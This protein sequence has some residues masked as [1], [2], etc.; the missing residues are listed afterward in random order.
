MNR[1]NLPVLD[2]DDDYPSSFDQIVVPEPNCITLG[3]Q[4]NEI[5][6]RNNLC[7]FGCQSQ[8]PDMCDIYRLTHGRIGQ[9]DCVDDQRAGWAFPDCPKMLSI[10]DIADIL[11]KI[12]ISQITIEC[13]LCG[14]EIYKYAVKQTPD[15]EQICEACFEEHYFICDCCEDTF[16]IDDIEEIGDHKVCPECYDHTSFCSNCG[17]LIDYDSDEYWSDDGSTYCSSCMEEYTICCMD[18]GDRFHVDDIH[19]DG[20]G[21]ILCDNC[22]DGYYECEECGLF[23][24]ESDGDFYTTRDERLLCPSCYSEYREGR[25]L[26]DYGWNPS[27]F[28]FLRT[29]EDINPVK[30][31]GV[32]LEVDDGDFDCTKDSLADLPH[33]WLCNDGSLSSDGIEV[34][35]HP[36]TLGYHMTRMPWREITQICKS[37]GYKS[38]NSDSDCGIHVHVSKKAF[39]N[40]S[41][42]RDKNLAKLLY[43]MEK[44]WGNMVIFSRRTERALNNYARRYRNLDIN[45]DTDD[46]LIYKCKEQCNGEGRHFCVNLN[47][48]GHDSRQHDTI[49]IRIFR[50]SLKLNTIYATLQFCD[51]ITDIAINSSLSAVQS[52]MWDDIKRMSQEKGYT[53]LMEYYEERGL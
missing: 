30:Y 11:Y 47:E 52:L 31:M 13:E 32:E 16:P 33:I 4:H 43:I 8:I 39:G 12:D 10:R 2:S 5:R 7:N 1:F 51:V 3:I 28:N 19:D 35:T 42:S 45:N 36:A 18:C 25:R 27:S 17:E 37:N 14:K 53:E 44:F 15:G 46:E 41:I 26:H 22:R 20:H 21:N 29:D 48:V 23:I 24:N 49:E 38:H 40:S 9:R 34:I 50:G 6:G